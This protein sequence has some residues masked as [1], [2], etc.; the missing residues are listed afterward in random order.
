[1]SQFGEGEICLQFL[2]NSSSQCCLR[3]WV[4]LSGQGVRGFT[5]GPAVLQH[6]EQ[7]SVLSWYSEGKIHCRRCCWRRLLCRF[8]GGAAGRGRRCRWL[9]APGGCL[10]MGFLCDCI[11]RQPVAGRP[12]HR[13]S[14]RLRKPT[15]LILNLLIKES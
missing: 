9:R 12:R 5:P 3:C 8:A 15:Q 13:H 7:G 4:S 2:K 10:F 1:M 14:S 6:H 11:P